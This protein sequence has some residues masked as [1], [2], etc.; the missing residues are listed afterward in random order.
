MNKKLESLYNATFD[1]IELRLNKKEE[2][3][4]FALTLQGNEVAPIIQMY[5]QS[6][7]NLL[8][9]VRSIRDGL[10]E[11]L[12]EKTISASCLA[13]TVTVIDPRTN[14]STDA[15]LFELTSNTPDETLS[16]YVP[17][18]FNLEKIIQ[19]PFQVS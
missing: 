10:K 5:G 7:S 19:K 14:K 13:Y 9:E 16:V 3:I 12:K 18:D 1:L 11:A 2:I 8:K 6:R 4:P 17:Y 15:V